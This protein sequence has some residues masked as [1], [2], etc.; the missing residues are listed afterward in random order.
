MSFLILAAVG[1][2]Q[3]PVG[4][5]VTVLVLILAQAEQLANFLQESARELAVATDGWGLF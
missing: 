5:A 4:F 2:V 3:L 1:F